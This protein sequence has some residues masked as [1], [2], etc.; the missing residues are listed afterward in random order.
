ML[1]LLGHLLVSALNNHI[2]RFWARKRPSDLPSVF[3]PC[4]TRPAAAGP[5]DNADGKTDDEDDAPAVSGFA[6]V[7]GSAAGG[8]WKNTT[9]NMGG[10]HGGVSHWTHG[11]DDNA[12]PGFHGG[13]NESEGGGGSGNGL[14]ANAG[15][16]RNCPSMSSAAV[17]DGRVA[18]S[19]LMTG[20][21]GKVEAT[22]EAVGLPALHLRYGTIE[23][24]VSVPLTL[25]SGLGRY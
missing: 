19:K 3:A 11:A 15:V 21:I 2:T 18:G 12:M 24:T 23:Y 22:V 20:P 9:D 8:G 5:D 17:V 13:G 4:C 10:A 25:Q 7:V 6:S 1:H 14:M 16:R